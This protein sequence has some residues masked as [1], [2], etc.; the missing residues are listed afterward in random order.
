MPIQTPVTLRRYQMSD[1]PSLGRV[2]QSAILGSR[3]HY[4]QAQREHWAAVHRWNPSG[5]QARMDGIQPWVAV[6]QTAAG[7]EVLGYSDV[8]ASGLIDHF[9]VAAQAHNIGTGRLLMQQNL[10]RAA[11][12]G[13][14]ELHSDV[15]QN[16]QGFYAQ[17]GFSPTLLNRIETPG[18]SDC[19]TA[20]MVLK[21]PRVQRSS[22]VKAG[23]LPTI[24]QQP[25]Q[26]SDFEQVLALRM[27][28]MRE[29]LERLG[30]FSPERARERFAA[31]FDP[32]H[33]QHVLANGE[34]VGYLTVVP[35]P[36]PRPTHLRLEH[37]YL[38]PNSQGTGLGSA[39][40]K[41]VMAKAD[42]AG[43][44]LQVTVL[45]RSDAL[46]FYLRHG[47]VCSAFEGVDWT[48]TRP[49]AGFAH[50]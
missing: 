47:F 15:S 27:A 42:V 6:A 49:V 24:A 46:R 50:P 37:L 34:R 28:C 20:R 23:A 13:L 10:S 4:N 29:S 17:F 38:L 16:A 21:L 11:E 14:A 7:E 26:A 45:D 1:A 36:M 40:L 5:W 30:R 35:V 25:A 8:Q 44:P 9:F 19:F 18:A 2:F 3:R 48:L 39:L 31:G 41:G 22:G 32:A 12:M 33:G 43:L